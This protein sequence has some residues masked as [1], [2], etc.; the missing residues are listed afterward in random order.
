MQAQEKIETQEQAEQALDFALGEP[1]VPVGIGGEQAQRMIGVFTEYAADAEK[2]L[3][4][5]VYNKD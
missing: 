5:I 2:D 4:N 3:R 1:Y